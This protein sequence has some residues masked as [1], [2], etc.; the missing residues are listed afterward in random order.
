MNTLKIRKP[1]KPRLTKKEIANWRELLD[2]MSV[3]KLA[4]L[5]VEFTV[6]RRTADDYNELATAVYTKRADDATR[7]YWLANTYLMDEPIANENFWEDETDESLMEKRER[8]MREVRRYFLRK[9][10]GQRPS[11]SQEEIASWRESVD[12]MPVEKLASLGVEL[13]VN[14]RTADEFMDLLVAIGTVRGNDS[15]KWM[16]TL[17]SFLLMEDEENAYW[18]DETVESLKRKLGAAIQKI[19]LYH[20]VEKWIS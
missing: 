11:L 14:R 10:M 5:A 20:G 13:M 18:G 19:D 16:E 3:E 2:S 4:A 9:E 12:T 1:R 6:N 17:N 8:G 15:E 7:W